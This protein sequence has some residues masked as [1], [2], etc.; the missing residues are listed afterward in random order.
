MKT[1]FLELAKNRYTTKVYDPKAKISS[2]DIDAL[3]EILHLTPSSINGQ[4]WNFIFVSD[5]KIKSALA[6]ASYFNKDRI[7]SAS[8]L[9]VFTAFRDIE[10]FERQIEKYLAEPTI[11]Y[12][13]QNL[14]SQ[15]EEKVRAWMKNQV[16]ISLGFFLSACASMEIDSTAMEG[17]DKKRYDEILELQH[18][19]TI[20]A[21]AIGYHH[22]DDFNQLSVKP[23]S[24]LA[25]DQIVKSV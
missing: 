18:Y 17:I 5:E 10:Q 21:V 22:P 8:H 12:Y 23:K 2:E 19:E 11:E 3:K 1:T 25:L 16:Y 24:R 20:F 13:R 6:E 14:K 15:G 7:N 4:P 9:V